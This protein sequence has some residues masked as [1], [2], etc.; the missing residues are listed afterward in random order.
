MTKDPNRENGESPQLERDASA[1]STILTE[2]VQLD[3]FERWTGDSG[4]TKETPCESKPSRDFILPPAPDLA[5]EGGPTSPSRG[6]SKPAS[7]APSKDEAS[8]SG[9]AK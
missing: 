6:G 4:W 8:R 9:G 5:T 1:S 2:P 7:T 3:L